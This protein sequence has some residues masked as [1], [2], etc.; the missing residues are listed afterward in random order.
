MK[1]VNIKAYAKLNLS[2]VIEGVDQQNYHLLDSFV[3][4]I[5]LYDVVKISA[6]KDKKVTIQMKGKGLEYLPPE[7]NN[8]YITAEKFVEQ[9]D[10]NGADI[11]IYKNIPVGS[12]LGGSSADSAGV[13]KGLGEIYNIPFDALFEFSKTQGSDTPFMLRGGFARIKGRG[14]QV[15]F[16]DINKKLPIFLICPKSS[17]STVECYKKYDELNKLNS[18][19]KTE[20]LIEKIKND[21]YE[22]LQSFVFNDLY[23]GAKLLNNDVEIAYQEGQ[24]FAPTAISMTGSG[25]AVFCMFEHIEFCRWASSRYKGKFNTYIVQTVIPKKEKSLYSIQEENL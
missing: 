9:F 5:D 15:E 6:R 13:I 2:L 21:E 4:S 18:E 7:K 10:T 25:S 24:A 17:V 8:A 22:N 19:N 16:L 23:E 20:N 3:C 12:G 1:R 11:L 14:E